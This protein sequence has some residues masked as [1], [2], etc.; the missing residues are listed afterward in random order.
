MIKTLEEFNDIVYALH[1]IVLL[2]LLLF[3]LLC[4]A[5]LFY[6]HVW[7]NRKTNGF[8][9]DYFLERYQEKTKEQINSIVQEI[10]LLKQEIIELKKIFQNEK[11]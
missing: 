4:G 10:N 7:K 9:G 2:L 5:I 8:S 6:V 11:S 1:G 3:G